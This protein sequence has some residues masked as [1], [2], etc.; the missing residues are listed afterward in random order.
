MTS[1]V[2]NGKTEMPACPLWHELPHMQDHLKHS[3]VPAV[4]LAML[5]SLVND[6]FSAKKFLL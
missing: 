4:L 2:K 1:G 3:L 6:K 5:N